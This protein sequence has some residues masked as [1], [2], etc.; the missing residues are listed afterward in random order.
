MKSEELQEMATVAKFAIVQKEGKREI[1]R[2]VEF[3][4]LDMILSVGY[5]SSMSQSREP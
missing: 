3:Y 4:N 5:I 1:T 2:F